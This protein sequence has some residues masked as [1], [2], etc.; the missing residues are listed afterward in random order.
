MPG[1]V[2]KGPHLPPLFP[3][4]ALAVSLNLDHPPKIWYW[5]CLRLRSSGVRI[6]SLGASSKL[7]QNPTVGHHGS[8]PL[9]YALLVLPATRKGDFRSGGK[10]FLKLR[11]L[12]PEQRVLVKGE[13]TVQMWSLLRSQEPEPNQE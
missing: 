13:E 9:C 8:T 2:T 4:V 1:Q 10:N 6:Q 12:N 7:N 5:A 3:Q 11:M